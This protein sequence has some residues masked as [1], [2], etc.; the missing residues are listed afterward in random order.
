ME[1]RKHCGDCDHFDGL[2]RDPSR[3]LCALRDRETTW[4]GSCAAWV[5]GGSHLPKQVKPVDKPKS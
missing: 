3:P 2:M 1:P 5:M 4:D